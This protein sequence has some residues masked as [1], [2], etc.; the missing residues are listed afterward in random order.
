MI[1]QTKLERSERA[2]SR[3]GRNSELR[4]RKKKKEDIEKE[5]KMFSRI[6]PHDHDE[7]LR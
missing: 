1:K 4:K 6:E 5:K 2:N 7:H 3:R